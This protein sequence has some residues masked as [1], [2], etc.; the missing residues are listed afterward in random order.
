MKDP[1]APPVRIEPSVCPYCGNDNPRL[2]ERAFGRTADHVLCLVCT[3][4]WNDEEE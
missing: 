4:S 1:H 2:Q 3:R